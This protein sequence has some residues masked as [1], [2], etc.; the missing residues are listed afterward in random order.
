MNELQFADGSTL[1]NAFSAAKLNEPL[2]DALFAPVLDGL[3]IV[4]PVNNFCFLGRQLRLI[5]IEKIGAKWRNHSSRLLWDCQVL[6]E[7][8]SGTCC[9]IL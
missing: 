4:E 5:T 2:D 6:L 9:A 7:L 3:Q 8:P 1:R